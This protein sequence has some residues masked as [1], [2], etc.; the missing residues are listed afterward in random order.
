MLLENR[1]L[2]DG[3]E[4]FVVLKIKNQELLYL[5]FETGEVVR[6]DL[7]KDS[8]SADFTGDSHY[9]LLQP[10]KQ[11]L[12]FSMA[13]EKKSRLTSD[14]YWYEPLTSAALPLWYFCR[15]NLGSL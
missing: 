6:K 5:N 8:G 15:G 4:R 1:V 10:E 2:D 3:E 13:K 12:P 14:D 9:E 11:I 7:L